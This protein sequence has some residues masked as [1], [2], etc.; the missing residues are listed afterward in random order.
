MI[1]GLLPQLPCLQ[2]VQDP[3]DP[4]LLSVASKGVDP[5]QEDRPHSVPAQ[6]RRDWQGAGS[7]LFPSVMRV[8]WISGRA[9]GLARGGGEGWRVV[10][11]RKGRKTRKSDRKEDD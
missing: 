4:V 5:A 9:G 11:S 10:E 2:D 1:H 3:A 7:E 6:P 8:V